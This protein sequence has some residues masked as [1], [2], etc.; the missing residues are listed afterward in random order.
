VG[1]IQ[2]FQGW[3]SALRKS[4]GS[5][6]LATLGYRMKPLRGWQRS[7][8][9]AR[10][11]R[12]AAEVRSGNAVLHEKSGFTKACGRRMAS[13]M[14]RVRGHARDRFRFPE[15]AEGG[16][17]DRRTGEVP[18]QADSKK[19]PIGEFAIRNGRQRCEIHPLSVAS[20]E[21]SSRIMVEE[22]PW[23]IWA[24]TRGDSLRSKSQIISWSFQ[25]GRC[26]YSSPVS[27]MSESA[28]S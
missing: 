19:R 17:L 8:Q 2:P 20:V 15:R 23:K 28:Y 27:V 6:F 3:H 14:F 12:L 24:T 5:S 22:V 16:A 13:P 25:N 21:P 4:Q 9:M 7:G 1:L 10:E 26:W 18:A 11:A